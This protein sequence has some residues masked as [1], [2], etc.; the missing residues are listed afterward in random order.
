MAEGVHDRAIARTLAAMDQRQPKN[1]MHGLTLEGI[2]TQLVEHYGWQELGA[3]IPINC[4]LSEPSVASTLKFLRRM[5]W[6][7]AKVEALFLQMQAQR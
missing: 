6:A 5:P 3:R 7:R 4:F 2:V 1:P